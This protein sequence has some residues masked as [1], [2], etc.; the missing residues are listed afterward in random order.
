MSCFNEL[1]NKLSIARKN[2]AS[3]SIH[4]WGKRTWEELFDQDE[5]GLIR[6]QEAAGYFSRDLFANLMH[7]DVLLA[8][9]AA[10]ELERLICKKYKEYKR[11]G[12]WKTLAMWFTEPVGRYRMIYTLVRLR[13]LH[14]QCRE[15]SVHAS[16]MARMP[17]PDLH[18]FSNYFK[19]VMGLLGNCLSSLFPRKP[20][21]FTKIFGSKK[22]FCH[23]EDLGKFRKEAHQVLQDTI[24]KSHAA[25]A[26]KAHACSSQ[27][28]L[29]QVQAEILDWHQ[30]H[31]QN[32]AKN[33]DK[34]SVDEKYKRKYQDLM[35]TLEIKSRL[36]S[37]MAGV[38]LIKAEST[39]GVTLTPSIQ[40]QMDKEYMMLSSQLANLEDGCTLQIW[41]HQLSFNH[42]Y[43]L[44]N[45]S[46]F[47]DWRLLYY[48]TPDSRG[49]EI[50]IGDVPGLADLLSHQRI[51]E[52]ALRKLLAEYH[53]G[54]MAAL[55]VLKYRASVS[56]ADP[57]NLSENLFQAY[58]RRIEKKLLE[59]SEGNHFNE[60][61]TRNG[62]G[63][64]HA[65]LDYL[66]RK[67]QSC[68]PV[69]AGLEQAGLLYSQLASEIA[70]K[71]VA[72]KKHCADRI[73]YQQN[74]HSGMIIT[75]C[76]TWLEEEYR[77]LQESQD[78][79][80]LS[81]TAKSL[82]AGLKKMADAEIRKLR[83]LGI[84]LS[85]I[86]LQQPDEWSFTRMLGRSPERG[87]WEE[88]I[89][90]VFGQAWENMP[91]QEDANTRKILDD[92]ARDCFFHY[93]LSGKTL[94]ELRKIYNYAEQVKSEYLGK[95]QQATTT[96]VVSTQ[97]ETLE[98]TIINRVRN[99]YL[100]INEA[101]SQL[102]VKFDR[103]LKFHPERITLYTDLLTLLVMRVEGIMWGI[104]DRETLMDKRCGLIFAPIEQVQKEAERL[105][106]SH[107]IYTPD[108]E[109]YYYCKQKNTLEKC[110]PLTLQKIKEFNE[111]FPQ[112]TY[113]NFLE[114]SQLEN[115]GQL[116]VYTFK[117]DEDRIT[118]RVACELAQTEISNLARTISSLYHPDKHPDGEEWQKLINN[119]K[120][121][122]LE[123][124]DKL[125]RN[126]QPLISLINLLYRN[127]Q[128]S[129]QILG[130]IVK[131]IPA[132][133]TGM[134][135]FNFTKMKRIRSYDA[136]IRH[137]K[138]TEE[139][140][141]S[142]KTH[143]KAINEIR[144]RGIKELREL[145]K[146]LNE[147]HERHKEVMKEHSEILKKMQEDRNANEQER[148]QSEATIVKPVKRQNKSSGIVH[149]RG[150]KAVISGRKHIRSNHNRI[151]Y[152]GL[153]YSGLINKKIS[154]D[155]ERSEFTRKKA[156]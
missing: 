75:E 6:P 114:E 45:Y 69:H 127:N 115:L 17:S 122:A 86:H 125:L 124:L 102:R 90:G 95:L 101:I 51:S 35:R 63:Q 89:T 133:I 85:M 113:I 146:R 100:D 148:D 97:P 61:E 155:D 110:C 109:L 11:A 145:E 13:E 87:E 79:A 120:N 56:G 42:T 138:N 142:S 112:K 32:I 136:S 55:P 52:S 43:V 22:M 46:L 20:G 107:Y 24:G 116:I 88:Q 139:R 130:E 121:V 118:T 143:Q 132:W 2:H 94:A 154:R 14:K 93:M 39:L 119:K 76:I 47:S 80:F 81:V 77:L 156:Y 9:L 36:L 30:A 147:D 64:L 60:A 5:N 82:V 49:S 8:D 18:A 72:M 67:N 96:L 141:I 1:A 59:E 29:N 33:I 27:E 134:N 44:D 131:C 26:K 3:A 83:E 37:G 74:Q 128:D 149:P 21:F 12:F 104:W 137:D 144:E 70:G 99:G 73:V 117:R 84:S 111:M 40:E 10:A 62:A 103:N 25:L 105:P 15:V 7:D 91:R 123:K 108:N 50:N 41:K 16:Q 57:Q 135:N 48:K 98:T 92:T 34:N 58:S 150:L 68:V 38:A 53:H 4:I 78:F 19:V 126:Q 140:F 153:F 28:D 31:Q 151:S 54:I 152:A 106:W 23:I 129:K 65:C 66:E 71:A